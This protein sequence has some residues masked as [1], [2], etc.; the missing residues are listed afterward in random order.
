MLQ[1]H[2]FPQVQQQ[3][4]I[5]LQQ[6]G[7]PAHY[8]HCVCEWLDINFNDK[9]IGQRGPFD[10]PAHSPDYLQWT[11]SYGVFLK[12]WCTKR[13]HKLFLTFIELLLTKLPQLIWNYAKT[14]VAVLLHDWFP[15]LNA[16]GNNL[17]FSISIYHCCNYN[18]TSFL[19]IIVLS[20]F[21]P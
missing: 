11:S 2:F 18:V 13:N 5:Y 12:T 4:D 10:W 19:L 9:C 20:L 21:Y 15:V 17:N 14:F 8:V 16:T 6:D 3:K 7:A 1:T